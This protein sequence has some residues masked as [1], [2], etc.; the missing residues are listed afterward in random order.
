MKRTACVF[1]LAAGTGLAVGAAP[2]LAEPTPATVASGLQ[3]NIVPPGTVTNDSTIPLDVKFRG[4]NIRIVELSIDGT[5]ITRQ[6]LT[7]R[8]GHG[9]LHFTLDPTLLTEG[10]HEILI[11]AYE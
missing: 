4:G 6:A 7:T 10:S 3:V 9:I 8:D 5:R 1:A 2:G 11:K